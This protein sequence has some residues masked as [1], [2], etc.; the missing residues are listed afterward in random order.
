MMSCEVSEML[1]RSLMLSKKL[2]G[3]D[4]GATFHTA[5]MAA[6]K[7]WL[8]PTLKER[9]ETSFDLRPDGRAPGL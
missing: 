3:N 8:G 4:L 9:E 1:S 6:W 7:M 2:S 5:R